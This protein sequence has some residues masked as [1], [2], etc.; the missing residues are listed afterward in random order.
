[1]TLNLRGRVESSL[2]GGSGKALILR[3]LAGDFQAL[4]ESTGF[5]QGS[6]PS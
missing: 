3:L 6:F 4:A 1:M 5:R 2:C